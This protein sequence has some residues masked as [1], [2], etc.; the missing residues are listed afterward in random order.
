MIYEEEFEGQNYNR[1]KS[2]DATDT[3]Y[4]VIYQNRLKQLKEDFPDQE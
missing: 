3:K 1:Y 2:R 4:E